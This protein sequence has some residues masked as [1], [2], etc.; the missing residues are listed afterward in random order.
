[1]KSERTTVHAD[2][3]VI[4]ASKTSARLARLIS[5]IGATANIVFTPSL[6]ALKSSEHIKRISISAKTLEVSTKEFGQALN[7]YLH[8]PKHKF[9][10]LDEIRTMSRQ[11]KIL[12][13]CKIATRKSTRRRDHNTPHP[14]IIGLNSAYTMPQWNDRPST[15]VSRAAVR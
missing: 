8:P 14:R 6:E 3:I 11:I 5:Q 10:T 7:M 9:Y 13:Q 1:M 15:R 4:G 12:E 2:V